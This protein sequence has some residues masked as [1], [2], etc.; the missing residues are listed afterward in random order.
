MKEIEILAKKIEQGHR[1]G[2]DE[3]MDLAARTDTASLC[4]LAGRLREH[5]TGHY[6]D[7]CSIMNA[8]SG[9]CTE[10]CKWCSQSKFHHTDIE[11]YPL[12]D[13]AEALDLA[14]HNANKGVRRFSLVTSGRTMTDAE[15]DRCCTIFETI[16]REVHISLCASMGLLNKSQ[17]VRLRESGV[18]RYHCNL[19]TAPSY[20][21]Q[22]CTTH[23]SAE[24]IQTIRWAQEAGLEVCSGGI[25][26]MGETEAHRI[27]LG[28]TLQELGIK[29]IPLNILNPIKGTALENMPPLSDDEVLRSAALLRIIN[30]E[31]HIRFAGGRGAV[32]HL[33]RT[34]L[35]AG[36][37]ASIVGDMLTT[38]G[39]DIDSDKAMF[40]KEGFSI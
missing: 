35:H 26:G 24:K 39:S 12:V 3:A 9:R 11:V 29:S 5:F 31:A 18:T 40:I 30:P 16:G 28:V 25:I 21:P 36:I 10:N 17:L 7:T 38:S 37:S 14:R 19:E 13:A 23:T 27:E 4:A 22:L 33:E 34:L 15:I 20:F 8:R 32:K 1:L 6:F 2:Y